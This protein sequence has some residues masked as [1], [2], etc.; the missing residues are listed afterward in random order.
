LSLL[1]FC[2]VGTF[3][4]SQSYLLRCDFETPC[5]N[6]ITDT[7]WG[8]T[9][10][11]HP[12]PLDHDH[13]LNDSSGHYLFYVPQN[14]SRFFLAEIKTTDW[15]QPPTDR[16]I[17]FQMWYYT[18]QLQLPFSI[19]L[20]Q[21]DDEQLTRVVAS[22]PGKDPSID[23]WTQ[24]NI[25]LPA[26]QIKIY[27]RLNVTSGQLAFDDLTVDYCDQPRPSPMKTL[28]AC[29]FESSCTGNFI[30][31]PDYP[32]QWSIIQASDAV[33]QDGQAPSIDYTFGNK[34]G[35][36]AWLAN[37]KLIRQGKVGYLATRSAFNFTA[38]DSYCLNFQYYG[39]GPLYE[40]HLQVYSMTRDETPVVQVLWPQQDSWQYQ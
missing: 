23:D 14:G 40:T 34:S 22:I 35:H 24:I 8:V 3:S 9:D 6:F 37:F 19:Q 25:P 18:P 31:L 32:Y 21:G 1:V 4:Y 7:N 16:A 11:L 27:V 26:E 36:Y 33:K 12:R 15:L 20:V 13:T 28:L 39:Y 38:N 17:C 29:D 10:G 30:S 2:L 5:V